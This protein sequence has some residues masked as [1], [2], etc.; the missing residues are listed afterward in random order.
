MPLLAMWVLFVLLT[1]FTVLHLM[2]ISLNLGKG[3]LAEEDQFMPGMTYLTSGALPMEDGYYTV[4]LR[5]KHSAELRVY[6]MRSIP[7]D[8]FEVEVT[9]DD[10]GTLVYYKPVSRQKLDIR[11]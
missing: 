5:R 9:Q 4:L 1:I 10:H 11:T 3:L 6:R 8:V 2:A 7:P